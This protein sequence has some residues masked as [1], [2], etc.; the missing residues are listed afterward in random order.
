MYYPKLKQ[1]PSDFRI[2][3]G[4][5]LYN[6]LVFAGLG[7]HPGAL[8]YEDSSSMKSNGV[9]TGYGGTGNTP[10]VMWKWDSYLSRFFLTFV[11]DDLNVVKIS[12]A[13]IA[14]PKCTLACWGRAR[15][16]VTNYVPLCICRYTGAEGALYLS[17]EGGA[18]GDPLRAIQSN[19]IVYAV[20]SAGTFTFEKWYHICGIFPALN[21]R[22]CYVNGVPGTTNTDTIGQQTF[23]TTF[24]GE[25]RGLNTDYLTNI[26]VADP[27]VWNRILSPSEISE[28]ADPSNVMLSGL[29]MPPARRVWGVTPS[30]TALTASFIDNVTSSDTITELLPLLLILLSD[31]ITTLDTFNPLIPTLLKT[32]AD[33]ITVSDTINP[34]IPVLL[35]SLADNV[36]ISDTLNP[37]IPQL[38]QSFVDNITGSDTVNPL[39][40]QLLQSFI[41]NIIANDSISVFLTALPDLLISFT[42]SINTSDNISNLIPI[43]YQ[44]IVDNVSSSDTINPL[45]PVLLQT[46]VDNVSVSDLIA[47]SIPMGR[48]FMVYD[49]GNGWISFTVEGIEV[50]RIY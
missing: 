49:S 31:Q 17:M 16:I 28:L 27:M 23:D 42:D 3:T 11:S 38:L 47:A 5:S 1:R 41:D 32:L 39:L 29:L 8:L 19:N 13:V 10:A 15:D 22:T 24:L 7:K 30:G 21:S 14:G 34:L 40:P 4:S 36:N 25:Y 18:S 44:V 6:G 50:V 35:Q 46:L 2:N 37:L 9:L 45:I 26:D 12:K 43:L 33:N 48:T 20:A